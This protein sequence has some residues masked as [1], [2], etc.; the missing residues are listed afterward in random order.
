MFERVEFWI[1]LTPLRVQTI[2]NNSAMWHKTRDVVYQKELNNINNKNRKKLNDINE[3][4]K[5]LV[6]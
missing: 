6:G 4:L 1:H 5:L 2:A 3:Q